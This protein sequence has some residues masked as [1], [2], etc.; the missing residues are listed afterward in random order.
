MI[1]EERKK[2]SLMPLHLPGLNRENRHASILAG[3]VGGTK[4]NLS[5][6]RLEADGLYQGASETYAS[7]DFNSVTEILDEFIRTYQLSVQSICLG[8]AGPV[9]NGHVE[10]TNLSW[11]LDIPEIRENTGIRDVHL[12]NDL[13]ATAY[14]L[15]GMVEE[16]FIEISA[17]SEDIPG[18]AAIIA[19]GTGLGEA[20]LFWDG[21]VYHPFPT[22]GG[23]CDF[24]PRT[25]LDFE[26]QQFLQKKYGVVSWEKLISGPGIP[27]IYEFL[28]EK[29]KAGE[30]G[31]RIQF[32]GRDPSA[33]ISRAAMEAADEICVETMDLF[34]RYLARESANLVLKMKALGGLFLGGGIPPK[35]APLIQ[36]PAFFAE[37][38]DCDRM[39]HLLEQVPMRIIMNQKAPMLGAGYYGA[40]GKRE[41]FN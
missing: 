17:G 7:A 5:V 2:R 38:M 33:V 16:D 18:N 10:L 11:D 20:G 32:E 13:E 39:Q 30:G 4:T 27:D 24:S 21:R 6:F 34:V 15:A 31:N 35:I 14:G 41:E 29:K 36:R 9:I 8:V 40:Y 1:S 26:L 37:Y 25:E 19:P 22:E 12:L 3:D 23:H 28:T